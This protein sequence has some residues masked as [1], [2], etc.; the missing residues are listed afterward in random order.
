MHAWPPPLAA[1]CRACCPALDR[2]FHMIRGLRKFQEGGKTQ[3]RRPINSEG[4][5]ASEARAVKKAGS[6]SGAA[7]APAYVSWLVFNPAGSAGWLA[8][9]ATAAAAGGEGSRAQRPR[10]SRTALSTSSRLAAAG[11]NTYLG[12]A[13]RQA[14]RGNT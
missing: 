6:Q 13:G 11:S 5:I 14:T 10:I 1:A 7:G 3:R 9:A 4:A 12:R 8:A 2:T